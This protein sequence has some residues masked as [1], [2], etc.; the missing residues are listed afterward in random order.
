MSFDLHAIPFEELG[1]VNGAIG[2]GFRE[3]FLVRQERDF[4][5]QDELEA[6]RPLEPGDSASPI[7]FAVFNVYQR[8]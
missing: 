6:L 7:L 1:V 5:L 4:E 2:F 3:L 8:S